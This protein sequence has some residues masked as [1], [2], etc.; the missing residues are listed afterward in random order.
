LELEDKIN[1]YLKEKEE[2]GHAERFIRN[3]R[4]DA[5]ECKITIRLLNLKIEVIRA[6]THQEVYG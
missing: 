6:K 4:V 3:L 5:F 1:K 2:Y